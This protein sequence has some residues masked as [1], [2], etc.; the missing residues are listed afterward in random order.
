MSVNR[1]G[2]RVRD[3]KRSEGRRGGDEKCEGMKREIHR[4]SI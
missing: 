4:S 3:K 1:T 2:G